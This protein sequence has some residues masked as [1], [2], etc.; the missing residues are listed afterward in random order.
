MRPRTNHV[1][2]RD[3]TSGEFVQF[4]PHLFC[5]R[6][7]EVLAKRFKLYLLPEVDITILNDLIILEVALGDETI[8]NLGLFILRKLTEG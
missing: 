7:G 2:R 3:H 4:L 5:F 1:R 6:I 8:D